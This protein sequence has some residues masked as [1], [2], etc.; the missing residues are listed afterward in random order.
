MDHIV[1]R[2]K[3]PANRRWKSFLSP[4]FVEAMLAG[5][6]ALGLAF[7]AL[8][9][10]VCLTGTMS[11]FKHEIERW[12]QPNAPLV[13]ASLT[14]QPIQEAVWNGYGQAL[15]DNAAQQLS[16]I[17]PSPLNPRFVVSYFDS[18]T[19]NEG[20]WIVDANG[21]FVTRQRAPF[22]EFVEGLHTSLHLPQ[23][24]GGFIVG[25]TGVALLSSLI[26]GLLSHPRMFKDA[27]Q[28]RWG[29]SERL[30]Y[31]DLHNR[32]AVW[33]LPFHVLVS[34][35]GALLALSTLIIGV[36]A[37]AAYQGKPEQAYAVILGPHARVTNKSG[38]VPDIPAMIDSVR[39]DNPGAVFVSAQIERPGTSGEVIRVRMRTPHHLAFG[40]TFF[41]DGFGK[42]LGD[43]G[44]ETGSVGQQILGALQPA[45]Y[46]WFGGLGTKV[47]YGLL[48]F[49]LVIVTQ[50]GVAVWLARRRA[51]GRPS[52]LAERLWP[53]IIW[54]QP[55]A[56]AL[57]ALQ[58]LR[59]DDET[60]P[61]T[62]IA[63]LALSTTVMLASENREICSDRLR[64][65]TG[66][67]LAI[68]VFVHA[69][70]WWRRLSDPIALSVSVVLLGIA[71]VIT[72]S[73]IYSTFKRVTLPKILR[74]K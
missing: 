37:A 8:I 3:K 52:L 29:G 5:H 10:I 22:A 42:S 21:H 70:I 33:G 18:S 11:V 72:T 2:L 71:A 73:S 63:A 51:K 40:N 55:F 1:G 6:S 9:Y 38:P 13:G 74:E 4:R 65:L 45:H 57:V 61:A 35:T 58:S 15:I 56:F 46:G 50:S 59:I 44:L 28:L 68:L 66:L 62:Y 67:V 36:L 34:T 54:S 17:A 19:G 49:A 7:A 23:G 12:E 43:A 39:R 53:T 32:L 26:S 31:A 14:P 16:L 41:F 60:L 69:W 24:L 47:V 30:Q 27:F 20:A 48:G 64:L 25:L